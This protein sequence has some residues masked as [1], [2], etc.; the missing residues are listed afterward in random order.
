MWKLSAINL[1]PR[2]TLVFGDYQQ[3]CDVAKE[4]LIHSVEKVSVEISKEA[5]GE[6][7]DV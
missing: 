7:I 1:Y 2:L 3:A 4:I 5:A 6:S